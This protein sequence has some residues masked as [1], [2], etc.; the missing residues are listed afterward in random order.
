MS[1]GKNGNNKFTFLI[2]IERKGEKKV[3]ELERIF[4]PSPKIGETIVFTV[5]C[6]EYELTPRLDEANVYTKVVSVVH[7]DDWERPT[8]YCEEDAAPFPTWA[9]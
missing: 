1:I 2:Q 5:S 8:I 9:P 3:L 4:N 7:S 6:T